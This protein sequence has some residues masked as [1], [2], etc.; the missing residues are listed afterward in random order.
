MHAG[1]LS[2]LHR[3]TLGA[4]LHCIYSAMPPLDE[5]SIAHFGSLESTRERKERRSL[6][7][8]RVNMGRSMSTVLE[9]SQ[10]TSL[11]HQHGRSKHLRSSRSCQ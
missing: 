6:T 11:A 4:L 3:D 2:I 10:A 1:G 7:S 8:A 5:A 9:L